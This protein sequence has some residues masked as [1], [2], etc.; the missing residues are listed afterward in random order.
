MPHI[1]PEIDFTV[2]AYIVHKDSVLL[3]NHKKLKKWLPIGG[4][5]ELDQDPE[6]A[7]FAEVREESGIQRP[8]LTVWGEKPS[9]ESEGTKFLYP[10]AFLDIHDI[11]D[12][13]RHVGMVFFLKSATDRIVLAEREHTDIKWVKESEL[14]SPELS[15]LPAVKFYAGE[16]FSRLSD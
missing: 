3:I 12:T 8:D 11:S 9:I 5:I 10:P 2:A 4:H 13:H 16:A 15:L 7:L 14:E 6:E 1:H